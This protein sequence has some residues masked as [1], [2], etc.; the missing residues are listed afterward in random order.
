MLKQPYGLQAWGFVAFPSEQSGYRTLLSS[1]LSLFWHCSAFFICILSEGRRSHIPTPSV[2]QTI[3]WPLSQAH[4]HPSPLHRPV[5]LHRRRYRPKRPMRR[6]GPLPIP[7][8]MPKS[9]PWSIAFGQCHTLPTHPHAHFHAHA[10]ARV[11]PDAHAQQCIA[12]PAPQTY[13]LAPLRTP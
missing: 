5:P 6:A 13:F 3:S 2:H 4:A 11:H 1:S 10:H 8:P 7:M 9:R 12:H